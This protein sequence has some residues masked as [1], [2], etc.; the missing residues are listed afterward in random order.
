MWQRQQQALVQRERAVAEAARAK[1]MAG[2]RLAQAHQTDHVV[3]EQPNGVGAN[4]EAIEATILSVLQSQQR[5]WN[6][7]DVDQF[8]EYYWKSEDLTFSSGGK[9]TRTWQGTLDNYKDRYPSRKDMGKLAFQ[10]LEVRPL[11]GEAAL[12]LGEWQLDREADTLAGN[13]T[14]VFRRLGGRWVIVHDH[15]SRSGQQ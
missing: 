12:V 15:T 2:Q 1:A 13:F 8:M 7:G 3:L 9:L 14:L 5:A 10:N 6:A 4:Y 11:G